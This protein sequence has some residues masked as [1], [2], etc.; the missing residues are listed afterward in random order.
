[1]RIVM[2][3]SLQIS[4]N[5]WKLF[6][7]AKI[8]GC[9]SFAFRGS[10]ILLIRSVASRVAVTVALPALALLACHLLR[11]WLDPTYDPLFI[12]ATAITA[13]LCGVPYAF[14]C[15][16]LS[17][18]ALDYF[19]LAPY[20]SFELLDASAQTKFFLFLAQTPSSSS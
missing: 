17:A 6:E 11:P 18:L 10:L 14:A 19:F 2:S 16:L 8:S 5:I 1:M 15:V 20:N 12:A 9:I 7:P 3:K 13:W 4:T